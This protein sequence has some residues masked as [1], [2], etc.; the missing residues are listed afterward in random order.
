[1]AFVK[2]FAR[3]RGMNLGTGQY[4]RWVAWGFGP[5]A[6]ISVSAI[7]ASGVAGNFSRNLRVEDVIVQTQRE[8]DFKV[9]CV[10]RN[11]GGDHIPNYQVN[12]ACILP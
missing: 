9:H 6:A 4:H 5:D 1:M 8:G 3:L 11:V 2:H 12:F 10:V 7:A